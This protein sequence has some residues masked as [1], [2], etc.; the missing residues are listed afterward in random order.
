MSNL[1]PTVFVHGFL[2]WGVDDGI[3]DKAHYWGATYDVMEYLREVGY[4]VYAPSLGPFGSAWDRACDLYARLFGGRVDYGKVHSEKYGHKRYGRTYPGLI[5]DLGEPGVHAKL[6]LVGHSFGAPAARVFADLLAT[7]SEEERQ[8]TP[9]EELSPLFEGGHGNLVHTLTTLSGVN[10]GST[11]NT[12]YTV[13]GNRI[14]AALVLWWITVLGD[15]RL[16]ETYDAHM[17][18][19]GLMHNPI[20]VKVQHPRVPFLQWIHIL[21]FVRNDLDNVSSELGPVTMKKINDQITTQPNTYYFARRGCRTR[22]GLFGQVPTTRMSI[23]C[24]YAGFLMGHFRPRRLKPYGF[25][26][27][28]LANDGYV[29]VPGLSAPFGAPTVECDS[30]FEGDFQPGRWHNMPVEEKDHLSWNG[31]GITD[32]NNYYEYYRRMLHLFSQLPDGDGY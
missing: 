10:N 3:D 25:D 20:D 29:N 23:F 9:A 8:G 12:L 1:Y 15:T 21:R 11:F 32:P 16:S 6:N 22:K 26:E 7:G 17:D 28:W 24:R 18:Q 31:V 19:W 2:G 4:E 30:L 27:T 5:P 14:A 13:P